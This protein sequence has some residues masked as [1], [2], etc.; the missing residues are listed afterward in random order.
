MQLLIAKKK[1]RGGKMKVK[2]NPDSTPPRIWLM[3]LVLI[4]SKLVIPF[5]TMEDQRQDRLFSTTPSKH[6]PLSPPA[7]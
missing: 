1:R 4:V 6:L 5:A 2:N 7:P 3:K